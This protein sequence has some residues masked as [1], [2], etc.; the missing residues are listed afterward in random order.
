MLIYSQANAPTGLIATPGVGS[1]GPKFDL[2]WTAPTDDG[3]GISSYLVEYST[4]GGS[5]WTSFPRNAAPGT[6]YS[7]Y[8]VSYETDYLFRISAVNLWGTGTTSSNSEVKK[9]AIPS[10]SPT[11]SPN[12][13]TFIFPIGVCSWTVPSGVSSLKVDARGGQGGIGIY[14][15]AYGGRVTGTLT[16]TPGETLLLYVGDE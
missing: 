2:A 1:M 10:C 11:T 5:T 9:V 15:F 3:G 16:V 12:G 4:N 6:S 7:V 8:P 13:A 14:G